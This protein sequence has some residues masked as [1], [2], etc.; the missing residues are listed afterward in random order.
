[1]SSVVLLSLVLPVLALGRLGS[2]PTLVGLL[3]TLRVASMVRGPLLVA[4]LLGVLKGG[5]V[6]GGLREG[7]SVDFI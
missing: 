5:G 2:S 7:V 1:V 3:V 6:R 4:P